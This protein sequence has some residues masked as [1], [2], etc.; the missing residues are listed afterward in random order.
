MQE[1]EEEQSICDR[2]QTSSSS[3]KL[4]G[5]EQFIALK[6]IQVTLYIMHSKMGSQSSFSRR[7]A[8]WW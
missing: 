7:K 5:P 6:H 4:T 8:E 1:S 2:V 3:E